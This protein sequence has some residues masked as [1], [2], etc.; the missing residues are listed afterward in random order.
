MSNSQIAALA[1]YML[2]AACTARGD[3]FQAL[4]GTITGSG[5]LLYLELAK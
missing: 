3:R 1:C 5:I 4:I 2:A